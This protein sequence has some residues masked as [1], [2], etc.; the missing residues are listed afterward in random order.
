MIP[1]TLELWRHYMRGCPSPD[2]WIDLGWYFAVSAAL[3][4][5]VWYGNLKYQPTF[6]NLY[7]I[8]VGPP[9]CG[10][11]LVLSQVKDLFTDP[12]M[13]RNQTDKTRELKPGEKVPMKVAL[14]P[15]DGSYQAFMDMLV[16]NTQTIRYGENGCY[17]HASLA[18]MLEEMNSMFKRQSNE[19]AN[20][21]L[22][23]FDCKDHEYVVRHSKSAYIQKTC[24]A[25]LA[26]CTSTMLR[27]AA[28]YGIFEDGFVSRCLFAFEFAPK[29]VR[30]DL[31]TE[32]D[33][34]QINARQRLQEHINKLTGLIGQIKF[35]PDALAY[36]RE[37]FDKYDAPRIA[38]S[39]SKMQTYFGRKAINLQKLAG[40]V[41]YS[42]SFTDTVEI[43]DC[44][45]ARRILDLLEPKMV[46][47]FNAVGRNEYSTIMKDIK[48]YVAYRTDGA[49]GP[50]ILQEFFAEV[51][52]SELMEL[53][54][55]LTLMGDI[56]LKGD[57]YY[58]K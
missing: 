12:S 18:I 31:N 48:K 40:V 5:R 37:S 29:F 41:H 32:Y 57:R 55:S 51:N 27:E 36:M 46:A 45:E 20:F 35:T 17:I 2:I 43:E 16:D 42:R 49:T 9:A 7:I 54:S 53:I 4:R 56:V 14:G 3:Q 25:M 47:G 15:S 6:L 8:F 23:T 28:K 19:V 38:S 24:V 1:P 34:E 39:R 22:N 44:V 30:F 58:G 50:E 11:G 21:L 52:V 26:C 10:K 13:R 33:A